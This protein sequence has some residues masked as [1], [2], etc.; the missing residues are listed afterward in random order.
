MSYFGSVFIVMKTAADYVC[1]VHFKLR[2]LEYTVEIQPLITITF[3]SRFINTTLN[4]DEKSN[5]IAYPCLCYGC[6]REEGWFTYL[7][8]ANNRLIYWKNYYL[9]GERLKFVNFLFIIFEVDVKMWTVSQWRS[10]WGH[11]FRFYMEMRRVLFIPHF[12]GFYNIFPEA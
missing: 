10:Q 4:I 8:S 1:G 7:K 9:Q 11:L 2:F 5:F 3:A 12:Y 6:A